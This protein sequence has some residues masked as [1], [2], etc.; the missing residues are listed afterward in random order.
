MNFKEASKWLRDNQDNLPVTL[1]TDRG[2]YF[3]DLHK[4]LALWREYYKNPSE[5]EL[6]KSKIISLVKDL[7]NKDNWN[8]PRPTM[9][10]LKNDTR[11][12]FNEK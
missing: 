7:Q 8:V 3:G 10:D 5:R 1:D 9:D 11:K 6:I 4:T 2:M 12:W